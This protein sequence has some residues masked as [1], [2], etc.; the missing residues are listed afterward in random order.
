M[1]D[2]SMKLEQYHSDRF[3][4]GELSL[5]KKD[6][7]YAGLKEHNKY[8]VSHMKDQDQYGLAQMLKEIWEQE[9]SGYPANTTPK[10]TNHDNQGKNTTHYD[11]KNFSYDKN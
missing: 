6:C 4:L 10:P 5:I 9:D 11:R 8:L 3:E 1:A 2:I 7:F